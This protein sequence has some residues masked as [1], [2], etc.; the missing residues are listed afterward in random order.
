MFLAWSCLFLALFWG[1]YCGIVAD[2]SLINKAV[3]FSVVQSS[4]EVAS[5]ALVVDSFVTGERS[6]RGQNRV[7]E[8]IGSAPSVSDGAYGSNT[9]WRGAVALIDNFSGAVWIFLSEI[10]SL[11]NNSVF[12]ACIA[13]VELLFIWGLAVQDVFDIEKFV[14]VEH[15]NSADFEWGSHRISL[16]NIRVVV[17]VGSLDIGARFPEGV[18]EGAQHDDG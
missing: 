7:W 1:W 17:H 9:V 15:W 14:S 12:I 18:D 8:I 16:R 4:W 2:A 13:Q 10:V 3:N 6:L 5:F 11:G